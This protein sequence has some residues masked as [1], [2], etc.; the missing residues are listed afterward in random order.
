MN[1][2]SMNMNKITLVN[3]TIDTKDIDSLI[4]WLRTNPQLTK[5]EETLAFEDAWSKFLG[6]KHSIFVNSGSSANLGMISAIKQS[7]GLRNNKVVVPAVSW[8]TT[9]APVMQCG[10]EPILC[11]CNL[12]NLGVDVQHLE[13]IF[14]K[15]QPSM[16]IIVHILGFPC[17]MKEIVELCEKHN[18]I[19]IEDS[20][21]SVGSTYQGKQTGSFGLCSSFSFYYGH[22]M[23][24]IEGGMICTNDDALA[25]VIRS[26]R[27]HGWDRDLPS[28]VQR[29]MRNESGIDDFRALYT[30]YWQGYNLR[31][32]DL[33][34]RIGLRQLE[35]LP[36]NIEKRKENFRHYQGLVKNAMWKPNVGNDISN[37]AYPVITD[38]KNELIHK[39]RDNHIECRPLVC[40]SIG[41]QP[42]WIK[43]YG[44]KKLTNADVV[45]EMGIYVPNHHNMS[46]EDVA[47]VADIINQFT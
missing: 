15:E 30:F 41:R 46:R 42:F 23:S 3:D 34:A 29:Q 36:L 35:K 7:I 19:L 47:R 12:D 24:T 40:G 25:N 11:D 27:S 6:V 17:D 2:R 22:H 5:G 32:T 43:K 13:D 45:D 8:S 33:Q 44:E 39:L 4:D 28:D 38:R 21:E 1:K 9:V 14:K 37:M 18:V 10:F 31:S 26:V 16:L 20:C